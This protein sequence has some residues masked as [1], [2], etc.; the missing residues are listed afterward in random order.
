MKF[1]NDIPACP[2]KT[3]L[4]KKVET[5]EEQNFEKWQE[6]I[7]IS[8]DIGE[9]QDSIPLAED[10]SLDNDKDLLPETGKIINH[11]NVESFKNVR[12]PENNGEW[13]GER[14]N[15]TWHPDPDYVPPEKCPPPKKPYSNPDNLSGKELLE[16]YNIDGI[17]FKNGYPIFEDISKGTVE[18]KEFETGGGEA[19]RHNFAKAYRTLAEQCGYTPQEVKEWMKENNYTWHE[20]E[21]KK[22]MQKVPNEI[23]ANIPHDGGRCQDKEGE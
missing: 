14:G 3:D 23:H 22:T 15:S 4:P 1:G 17:R 5:L 13:S 9:W 19:K 12:C 7:E 21:D 6:K 20:C 18:I 16:K 11:S 8:E 10:M 2:E